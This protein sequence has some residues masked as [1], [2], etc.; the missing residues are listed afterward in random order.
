[1]RTKVEPR[2]KFEVG[3]KVV[4]TDYDCTFG[5]SRDTW[6]DT[7][8][9]TT[10]TITKVFEDGSVEVEGGYIY[11]QSYK[12][13]YGLTDVHNYF[14][15][16]RVPKDD[17]Y[18]SFKSKRYQR[19]LGGYFVSDKTS[20][21]G[22]TYLFKLTKEFEDKMIKI[23]KE[24]DARELEKTQ[25]EKA[26]QEKEAKKKPHLDAYKSLIEPLEQELWEKKCEAWRELVCSN[27]KYNVNGRCEK[28]H[29]ENGNDRDIA[30]Q[31]V[32]NC[33]AFEGR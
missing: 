10:T 27:C 8:D 33:S 13:E 15:I 19:T 9:F 29:D 16:K 5:N 17:D 21:W 14:R 3:E 2:L 12:T 23:Q 31:Q 4:I 18:T 24:S 22:V 30:T 25:R 32:S 7:N 20:F 26:Y 28:W 1:M 6:P 11:R